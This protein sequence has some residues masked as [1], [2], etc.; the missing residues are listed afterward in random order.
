MKET[1]EL[2]KKNLENSNKK[3]EEPNNIIN[4]DIEKLQIKWI[5]LKMIKKM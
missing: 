1:E 2:K 3:E 5:L 4:N